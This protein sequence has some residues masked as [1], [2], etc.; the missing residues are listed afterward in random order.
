MR[1]CFSLIFFLNSF[2]SI[3]SLIISFCLH[4]CVCDYLLSVF[5][6]YY[7]LWMSCFHLSLH[8]SHWTPFTQ[9]IPTAEALVLNHLL[10]KHLTR[11]EINCDSS[12]WKS[13]NSQIY[14]KD[15]LNFGFGKFQFLARASEAQRLVWFLS[16][17]IR[18]KL[19]WIGYI[20]TAGRAFLLCWPV[21]I[22]HI[23]SLGD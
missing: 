10:P 17:E 14:I 9:V 16:Y 22:C 20:S 7:Q 3:R 21:M 13:W 15:Q 8:V 4:F 23:F 5:W 18:S 12:Y 6:G 1:F 2:R 11:C 19:M